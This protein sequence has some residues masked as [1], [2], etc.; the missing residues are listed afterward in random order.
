MQ[1]NDA[2]HQVLYSHLSPEMIACCVTRAFDNLCSGTFGSRKLS[3][4][5][6]VSQVICGVLHELIVQEISELPGWSKGEQKVDFDV[7][8]E[9]G[10]QL[11]IKTKSG[12]EGIAGNRY[13]PD[14]EYLEASGFYL[15]VNFLP[16]ECICKIRSGWVESSWW[17]SQSGKGN[18]S[19]LPKDKLD[20]LDFIP[21]QYLENLHLLA[22]DGVGHKTWEKL[23]L[24][25]FNKISDLMNED[26]MEEVLDYLTMKQIESIHKIIEYVD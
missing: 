10:L 25:G 9:S 5:S 21:G 2:K 26:A 8:H 15:C 16:F 3:D 6:A 22:V 1:V 17:V 24:I 4:M 19:T 18:A 11:Q 14:S 12:A 7:V 13:A 23:S 20:L